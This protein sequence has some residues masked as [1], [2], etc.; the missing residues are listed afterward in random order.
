[1]NIKKLLLPVVLLALGVGGFAALKASKPKPVAAPP[2][3]QVWRVL[4]Q[5]VRLETLSPGL[6][7]NG[8][9]EN[10][11]LTKAAAPGVG[12]VSRV[13]VRE[14]QP[15]ARGQLLL[16][17]DGRDFAPRV[18]QARGVVDELT[19][20][21]QGETLRHTADLDQMAQEKRLLELA[22]ADV[23]R[24]EQLRSENF[25]SQAAVDQSRSNLTR[26]QITLRSRELAV[27][28]HQAR[29]A[30]LQARLLQARASLEQAE[31]ALAR[32]QVVAPFAGYVAS[33]EVAAGDQLN[34]GQTLVTLYPA[35]S[36]EVRA[37]IPATVQDEVLARLGQGLEATAQ[38]A[39]RTVKLRLARVAGAAD[40][41]G[42]DGFFQ[43][44]RP[45]PSLRLG[46]LL[47]LQLRRAPVTQAV[48]V[49]YTSLYDGRR[50]YVVREGR[51]AA[52]EV[53]VLGEQ[54]GV[55]RRLLVQGQGL[56][57]GDMVVTT[58]LPNAVNGLRVEA[59]A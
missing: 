18:E 27:A 47:T 39:G 3:E 6:T 46:S 37:K 51:L 38:V 14:G 26:Q 16:E 10:P 21:I 11:A 48:S 58:H 59:R 33:L 41:R 52:V 45:E 36:M 31:L 23:A 44:T 1:M 55:D 50:V 9:V 20:S 25:Y 49:P 28:D 54:D 19:A 22:A 13:L 17:M 34:T 12:R 57:D 42:L 29:L 53:R 35:D 7:L 56:R 40:T 5:P 32:S 8:R 2:K 43:L 15:V 24:F 4:V 30:Q